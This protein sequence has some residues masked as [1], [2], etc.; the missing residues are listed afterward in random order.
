MVGV[1]GHVVQE[2]RQMQNA[3]AH[4]KLPDPVAEAIRL[5]LSEQSKLAER[6]KSLEHSANISS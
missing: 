2:Q 6:V 5:V 1:P 3:L 4:D